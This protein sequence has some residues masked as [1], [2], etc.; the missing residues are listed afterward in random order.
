MPWPDG[1]QRAIC[2]VSCWCWQGPRCNAGRLA[3]RAPEDERC[4]DGADKPAG[5]DDQIAALAW[6]EKASASQIRALAEGKEMKEGKPP[7]SR[8]SPKKQ[9]TGARPVF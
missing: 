4:G 2:S 7:A 3:S 8:A 1:W 5:R 6:T 9:N